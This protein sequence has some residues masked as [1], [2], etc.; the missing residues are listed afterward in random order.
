MH[1]NL[2]TQLSIEKSILNIQLRHR[3]V[4]NRGHNK[5]CANSGHMG[6]R[7]KSLI[8]ITALLLLETT[9]HKTR[10]IALKRSIRVSLNLVYPLAC[11]GTNTRRRRDKIPGDSALKHNN[12]LS[13]G[14]LPFGITHS[15]PIRSHLKGNKK[16]IVARRIAIRWMT[17]ASRKRRWHLVRGR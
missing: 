6:H 8:I 3:P 12:F 7:G 1:V 17:M 14:K 10:F 11:D 15:I 5:N 13:H 16:T 2:L 9:S 4:A